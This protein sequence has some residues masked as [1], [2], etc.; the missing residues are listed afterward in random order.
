MGVGPLTRVLPAA[1][2]LSVLAGCGTSADRTQVR[3]VTARFFAAIDARRGG[4]ACAQLSPALRKALEQ[5][6]AV[7]RCADAVQRLKARGS[8][9]SGVDVYATSARVQ[10]ASGESVFLSAMRDGWRIAALG[11]RA[12]SSGP[13]DCEEQA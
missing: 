4:D 7:S 11:C 9:I 12:R 10:L 6:H 13:Y 8:A 3:A 2:A 1:L 5:E